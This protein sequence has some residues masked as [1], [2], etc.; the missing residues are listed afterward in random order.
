MQLVLDLQLYQQPSL[1]TEAQFVAV[2]TYERAILVWQIVLITSLIFVRLP[3]IE[4]IMEILVTKADP[5]AALMLKEEPLCVINDM[6]NLLS[7]HT[8]SFLEFS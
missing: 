7:G 3:P 5:S 2:S 4:A 1:E 8:I 6:A